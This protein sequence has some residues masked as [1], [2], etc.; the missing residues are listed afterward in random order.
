MSYTQRYTSSP[1]SC[2]VPVAP[3][4]DRSGALD[5]PLCGY[6]LFS[7]R[8]ETSTLYF[9]LGFFVFSEHRNGRAREA[10]VRSAAAA[11]QRMSIAAVV[12]AEVLEATVQASKHL[13]HQ[14]I[15]PQVAGERV[16]FG[17][18]MESVE[19]KPVGNAGGTEVAW[20]RTVAM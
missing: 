7:A 18:L 6:V 13:A 10:W 16:V 12:C 1:L 8:L 5:P 15:A 19:L 17:R 9:F 3:R 14:V 11:L 20:M 4:P 2:P